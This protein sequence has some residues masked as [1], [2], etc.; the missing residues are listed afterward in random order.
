MQ[1]GMLVVLAGLVLSASRAATQLP[2][3]YTFSGDVDLGVDYTLFQSSGGHYI[4]ARGDT[5]YVVTSDGGNVYCQKSIDGGQSFGL[6]VLVNTVGAADNPSMRVDTAGVVYVAYQLNADIYFSKST[7]GGMSFAPNVKVNDDAIPQTG[8][9]TPDISV[10][11]KGQIFLAWQ[12]QRNIPSPGRTIFTAVSFD[13][14][15]T[16]TSNIQVNE[17][18]TTAGGPDIVA[19]DSGRVHIIYGGTLSGQRGI[20]LATS[21]DSG[22]SYSHYT[23]AS[24]SSWSGGAPSLAISGPLVGVAWSASRIVGDSVEGSI[25]FSSSLDYGR[26][27]SPSIR[28]D[29]DTTGDFKATARTTS[30]VSLNDKFFL[31]WRE[32]IGVSDRVDIF[33]SYSADSGRTFATNKQVNSDAYRSHSLPS[34]AVNEK[35]RTFVAWRDLRRDPFFGLNWHTFVAVGNPTFLKGDLNLDLTLTIADVVML[36]NA[37]FLGLSFPAPFDSADGNCDGML[38]PTDVVLELKTV[39]LHQPFPC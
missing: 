22:Q 29:E 28:I 11:N 24:D 13:G 16:F 20:V 37:V 4:G 30:L 23:L 38:S 21:D 9:E 27:F 33:F 34:I 6:P 2:N 39:F 10:N 36:L 3:I 1:K 15:Q 26:T 17:Q 7:D 8:Q 35:G 5:V 18:G 31:T 14:G 19:D 25:R 12:D 32:H